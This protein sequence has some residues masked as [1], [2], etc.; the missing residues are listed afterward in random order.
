ME[1]FRNA[2]LADKITRPKHY[3]EYFFGPL[4]NAAYGIAN[5][6]NT[7]VNSFVQIFRRP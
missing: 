2:C 7:A 1:S 3:S 4:L 5:Q 6:V